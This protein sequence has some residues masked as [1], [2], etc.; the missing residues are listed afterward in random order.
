MKKLK[1]FFCVV[2]CLLLFAPLLIPVLP[3]RADA[4]TDTIAIYVG[5]FGWEEDQYVEK[6]AYTWR[7]LDD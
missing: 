4:V 5:Y 3:A 1:R 6:A 7:E 2:L